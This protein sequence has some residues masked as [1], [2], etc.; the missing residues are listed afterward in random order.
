MRCPYC[1]SENWLVVESRKSSS[2]SAPKWI[3]KDAIF[4]RKKCND[5]KM[6]F[7]TEERIIAEDTWKPKGK[8]IKL[9]SGLD[10]RNEYFLLI[11]KKEESHE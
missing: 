2:K 4:R 10:K 7:N 5:C 9:A 1:G 8:M 11:R 6:R 3:G